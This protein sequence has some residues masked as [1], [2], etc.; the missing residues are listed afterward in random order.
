MHSLKHIEIKKAGVDVPAL[1][2]QIEAATD[3][4]LMATK[5]DDLV[6]GYI[7]KYGDDITVFMYDEDEEPNKEHLSTL[8]KKIPTET[9]L[10][11]IRGIINSL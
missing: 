11:T 10:D 9:E 7:N 6:D 8:R 4:K 2:N 3:I 5:D 1:C